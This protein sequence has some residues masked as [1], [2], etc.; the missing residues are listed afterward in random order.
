MLESVRI[1][2]SYVQRQRDVAGVQYGKARPGHAMAGVLANWMRVAKGIR[3]IWILK[4]DTC[5]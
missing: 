5:A 1:D 4:E 2:C 3:S